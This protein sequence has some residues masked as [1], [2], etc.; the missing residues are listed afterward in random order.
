MLA[1]SLA[2]CGQVAF[3]YH[4]AASMIGKSHLVQA[5]GREILKAGF[6]VLGMRVGTGQILE[7]DGSRA[8]CRMVQTPSSSLWTA[9]GPPAMLAL[10]AGGPS[11]PRA[12]QLF[13]QFK[14]KRAGKRN[15]RKPSPR[16]EGQRNCFKPAQIP[17][18]C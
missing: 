12:R 9:L 5:I 13:E 14:E 18:G 7:E 3:A 8:L 15:L 17:V 2:C 10:V 11:G 6:L 1:R 4:A 16:N